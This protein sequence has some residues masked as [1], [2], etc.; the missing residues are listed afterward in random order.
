MIS[1]IYI[2]LTC[3]TT[4]IYVQ[5]IT[6]NDAMWLIGHII[7]NVNSK[8]QYGDTL[9]GLMIGMPFYCFLA[10][11]CA[12]LFVFCILNTTYRHTTKF[13]I[14]I[15]IVLSSLIYYYSIDYILLKIGV[16]INLESLN[17]SNFNGIYIIYTLFPSIITT[18]WGLRRNKPHVDEESNDVD[19]LVDKMVELN[20]KQD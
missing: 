7:I 16:S 13:N 20:K 1:H 4:S 3:F 5:S 17:M 9:Y 14:W 11:V 19:E 6:V 8:S 18:I 15:L 10:S 2:F 12:K